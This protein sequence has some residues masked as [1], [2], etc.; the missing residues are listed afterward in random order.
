MNQLDR[1]M[2]VRTHRPAQH[3]PIVP[4]IAVTALQVSSNRATLQLQQH[5]GHSELTKLC[6]PRVHAGT[7][8]GPHVRVGSARAKG[9]V[10]QSREGASVCV[11][12]CLCVTQVTGRPCGEDL[13][14]IDSP[15]APT[16]MESCTVSTKKSLADMIP[17]AHP[18]AID[19]LS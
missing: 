14:A 5:N 9:H 10:E 12:V 16:M 8:H 3:R 18:D 2:E 19:L 15:F 13:E 7:C 1:I 6:G 17:S 4:L 11:C